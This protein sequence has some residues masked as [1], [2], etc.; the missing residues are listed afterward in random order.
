MP[1]NPDKSWSLVRVRAREALAEMGGPDNWG[2]INVAQIDTGVTPHPALGAWVEVGRGR[3]FIETGEPP[4]DPMSSDAM[5]A[6]HGTRTC[7]VLC[8]LE[9]GTFSGA[10]P[11]LPVIPYR[12]TDTVVIYEKQVRAAIAAAINDAVDNGC[13]VISI[14]LGFPMMGGAGTLVGEAV[15]RA[16]D[17]GII[18]CAAGGQ[19]VDRFC[20]PGK[21]FR[22]IGVGGFTGFTDRPGIYMSYGDQGSMNAFTDVW[23]PAAPIWRAEVI[24]TPGSPPYYAFGDGTSF[25]TPHVAAAAAMWLR[26]RGA[27]IAAYPE[28]W[29]RIEAFRLLLKS[30]AFD[31]TAANFS[32][33]DAVR[34]RRPADSLPLPRKGNQLGGMDIS[35]G[36]DMLA[37]LQ[38]DPPKAE[39]LVKTEARAV[40]QSG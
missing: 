38:E 17:H 15:D 21:Y 5:N 3:N 28:P 1:D 26:R 33:F 29:M 22:T 12:V 25:A 20:Y 8:G 37:L 24:K 2:E 23:A 39:T 36:L 9:G 14:S 10:A 32:G 30:T 19:V 34:P 6:G 40:D 27:E 13:E 16:Y 7:S 11:K 4:V 35:G 31:L 18:I